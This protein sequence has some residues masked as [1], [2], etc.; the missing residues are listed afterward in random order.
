MAPTR[1]E[2]DLAR[3][4]RALLTD[5]RVGEA[6]R[7]WRVLLGKHHVVDI[8]YDDWLRG[9]ADCYRALRRHREC[10]LIYLFLHSFDRAREYFAPETSNFEL[11]VCLELE[12]K[13]AAAARVHAQN[14]R[15]VMAAI[16]QERA[17]DDG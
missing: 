12:R 6:E 8:E 1:E 10:A 9:A 2:D 3:Q 16:N 7:I 17:G 5:G 4:A 11:A 13:Y 14:G 15:L